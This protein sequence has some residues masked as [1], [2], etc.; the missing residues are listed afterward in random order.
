MLKTHKKKLED[1]PI[2]DDVPHFRD[3]IE[4]K[5]CSEFEDANKYL[6]EGVLNK[7]NN[8]ERWIL[9]KIYM[10]TVQHYANTPDGV[11]TFQKFV[12]VYVLGKV[13]L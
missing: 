2:A 5:E 7:K 6:G 4:I 3:V 1:T 8:L 10:N 13:V 11:K 12:K 9:L